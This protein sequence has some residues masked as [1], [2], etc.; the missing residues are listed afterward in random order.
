MESMALIDKISKSEQI[1]FFERVVGALLFV[2][3][4]EGG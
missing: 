1:F 3:L 2:F 4:W